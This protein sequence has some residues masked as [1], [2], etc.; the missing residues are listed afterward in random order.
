[1]TAAGVA[2]LKVFRDSH[3]GGLIPFLLYNLAE[4]DYDPTGNSTRGRYL[5]VFRG[6]WSQTTGPARTD[7]TQLELVEVP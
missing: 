1:M 7:V 3:Q 4:G 6:G 5:V 2:A